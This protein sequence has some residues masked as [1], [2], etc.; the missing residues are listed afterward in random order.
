ML[1]YGKYEM[2]VFCV[3]HMA[4]MNAAFCMIAVC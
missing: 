4:V 2:F 3:H 1:V